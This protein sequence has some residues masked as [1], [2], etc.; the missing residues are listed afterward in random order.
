VSS[1]ADLAVDVVIDNYNYARFLPQAIDSALAQTHEKVNVIVVDDGS[2][3]DSKK[4]MQ[5][6]GDR[7]TLVMKENGGHAS[8]FNAG[9]ERCE[10]DVV[11]FLDAD[12]VLKPQAAARAAAAFAADGSVVK[13]QSRMEVVDAE[14]RPTG[15]VKP[16]AHLPMP[17]GDMSEAE[18]AFPFDLPWVPTSANAF[19]TEAMRRIMPIPEQDF[20]MCAERYLVHL[21]ALLG[22]VVSLDEVGASYRVHGANAYESEKPG[23][24]LAHI[25]FTIEVE[26]TIAADLLGLA[27]ELG[28]SRPDRILSLADLA[29]RMISLR[30]QPELHPVAAD[31]RGSLLLDSWRAAARRSNV[32]AAMKPLFVAW[33][34][35]MAAL[36]RPL[37]RHLALIF[38]FPE[39]RGRLNRLLGRFQSGS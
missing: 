21:I 9:V 30:L 11:I 6:Y 24:D 18:L 22:P 26:Q 15:A 25:R 32:S 31:G 12:D 14:E 36:P 1:T 2:T 35:A 5:S 23:L 34:A 16:P 29:N 27:G 28:L 37:A 39:R 20:R 17:N 33:F 10:G 4:V 38:L 8:A 19:R 13:V 7:A 3:D